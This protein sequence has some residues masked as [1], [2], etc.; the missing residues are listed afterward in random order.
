[1]ENKEE[2]RRRRGEKDEKKSAE[3]VKLL[4]VAMP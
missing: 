1:M 4:S 3:G 2:V